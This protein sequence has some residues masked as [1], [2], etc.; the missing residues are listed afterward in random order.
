[1]QLARMSTT[2]PNSTLTIPHRQT[3]DTAPMKPLYAVSV[4]LVALTL[5]A[6]PAAEPLTI[7][8]I[9]SA[10]DLTGPRLRAPQLSPD[11][12]LLTYL[13]GKT[14]NA[15]Q[16]DLWAFDVRSGKSQL[17]VDSNAF[18]RGVEQL[19]AGEETR[20]ERQRIASLRGIVDYEFSSDG[21]SLL[22]P[23]AGDVYTYNLSAQN[24]QAVRRLTHTD[25]YEAEVHLS[26]Q[27]GYVSFVRDQDLWLIE[28]NTGTERR[29]TRD[30]GGAVSNGSA[31]FIAQEEMGRTRGYWW[32]PDERY[33][34]YA[35]VDEAPVA[36]I[37]RLQVDADGLRTVRQRYPAAGAAN[38]D[39]TLHVIDIASG[40]QRGLLTVGDAYLPDVDWFPNSRDLAVQRQ[41]RNQQKLELLKIDIETGGNTVL[42]SETSKTWLNLND[43]F[44]FIPERRQFI[45]ASS[46]T[47]YKHLYLYDYNGKLLRPLT[48]GEWMVVGDSD[49]AGLVGVDARRGFVYFM[50]NAQS[51]L[52]RHLYRVR[53]DRGPTSIRRISKEPGWHGAQLLPDKSGY[54]DT[55]SSAQHPPTVTIHSRDGKARREVIRNSLDA[56]H[57]YAPYLT[58]HSREEFG[59]IRADGHTLHYRLLKPHDMQP[60]KRYPVIVDVYGGPG[61]QYVTD[62]FLGGSRATQGLF[63]QVLA[64][65]GFVVFSLDN[66]GS[67]MRGESFE[68]PLY[69]RLGHAEVRDQL[70]GVE[71]LKSLPFVDPERIGIM[72]WSYGGYMTLMAMTQSNVFK[73]G[74]AGAPV[75]DWSLYDTHYTERFLYT[76]QNNTDGYNASNVLH[77]AEHLHG[78]L[79][80]VHGMADD[81]VLFS[82]STQL[83]QALQRANKPF[84]L[85]TYPGG[86]HGL[87]RDPSMG[88][89]HY[90]QV[91]DFFRERL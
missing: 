48:T 32:S 80:L 86:K 17:L 46:R 55:W 27:G 42:L 29:L 52:E 72:G 41:S 36:E 67:G 22:I 18:I 69:K 10:P 51:P 66:R 49:S 4:G 75:T 81:N 15:N 82:H 20:R 70:R 6:S 91:L 19:S 37:E 73:A 83:M 59:S 35:R 43:D 53:L 56:S 78:T 65:Q 3:R 71:F 50:A 8:R 87:P 9:F 28:L 89:Y 26:P 5:A 74:M 38:V 84:Q 2:L 64:Q 11:G 39:V 68:S 25:S 47:G 88:R 58:H 85:M 40:E 30:G 14:D 76:P 33:I 79:L 7:E 44:T 13:Q 61:V 24:K 62:S 63:R 1:M 23:I 31:E 16:L 57:P 45:W 77:A 60:D 21:N 54:L 12:N 34:A 90:Q